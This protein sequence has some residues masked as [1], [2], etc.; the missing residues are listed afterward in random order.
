MAKGVAFGLSPN[1]QNFG[2]FS[3]MHQVRFAPK[4]P[5]IFGDLPLVK[6]PNILFFDP[7]VSCCL[8]PVLNFLAHQK[9]NTSEKETTFS[10]A[11]A[12][13]VRAGIPMKKMR[14]CP[15]TVMSLS[16]NGTLVDDKSEAV[17]RF[18]NVRS[19]LFLEP[20]TKLPS[21]TE[22]LPHEMILVRR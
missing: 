17:S 4:A 9:R 20:T 8:L 21:T 16:D 7:V 5:E 15:V 22:F 13:P 3:K 10:P 1:I 18:K 11:R 14:G 12:C 2:T 6:T 19:S